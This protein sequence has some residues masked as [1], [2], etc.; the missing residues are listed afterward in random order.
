MK[1]EANLLSLE[2]TNHLLLRKATSKN[3]F[4]LLLYAKLRGSPTIQF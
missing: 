3:I 2:N 4:F 1:E